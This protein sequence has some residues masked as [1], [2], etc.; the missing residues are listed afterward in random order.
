VFKKIDPVRVPQKTSQPY[1]GDSQVVVA[2]LALMMIASFASLLLV[3]R[4]SRQR[5]KIR[6][7]EAQLR[8][9]A[10]HAPVPANIK[11]S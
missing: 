2:A 11:A 9:I 10:R 5:T 7:L 8:E 1:L 4:N 6:E 3:F